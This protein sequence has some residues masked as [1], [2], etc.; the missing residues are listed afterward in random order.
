M[1]LLFEFKKARLPLKMPVDPVTDH[2]TP[3]VKEMFRVNNSCTLPEAM[4]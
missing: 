3:L 1:L 2:K 4:F